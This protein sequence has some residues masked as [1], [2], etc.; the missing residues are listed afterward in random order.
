MTSRLYYRGS[1][2]SST[3]LE[4]MIHDMMDSADDEMFDHLCSDYRQYM[5]GELQALDSRLWWQPET[6]EIF[7][8]D[9]ESGNELPDPDD[10]AEWWQETTSNWQPQ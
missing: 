7:W 10:F 9:D 8:Q 4:N 5:T 3:A 6:S 2:V 1:M